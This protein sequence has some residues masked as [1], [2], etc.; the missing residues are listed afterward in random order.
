MSTVNFTTFLSRP[1]TW[2]LVVSVVFP[3]KSY[4]DQDIQCVN[5]CRQR[6]SWS[7]CESACTYNNSNWQPTPNA[8]IGKGG[9]SEILQENGPTG[10]VKGWLEGQKAGAHH[11]LIQQQ[12]ENQ[13]LQNEILKRQLNGYQVPPPQPAATQQEY[14]GN[15]NKVEPAN[16]ATLTNLG[17]SYVKGDGVPKDSTKAVELFRKAA[18]Q[19]NAG[20]MNNLGVM[21]G[22]G[23]G[24]EQSHTQ[25]VWFY[26]LAAEKG[27]SQAQA[28]LGYAYEAGQGVS[29]DYNTALVWY[30][31]AAEMGHEKAK[32]RIAAIEKML[33]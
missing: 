22:K 21:Y 23:L 7:F 27:D 12:I 4:A 28:N 26:R 3:L 17:M 16:A 8:Q 32:Q 29:R 20:A 13:K 1:A 2:I 18:S 9:L 5:D 14:R 24:V 11:A 15:S 33:Q 6:Y 25:A 10:L 19:G 31:K 30:Q